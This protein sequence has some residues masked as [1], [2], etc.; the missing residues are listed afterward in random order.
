VAGKVGAAAATVRA[1]VRA[2]AT[3]AAGTAARPS[4]QFR[5]FL[6]LFDVDTM[7]TVEMQRLQQNKANKNQRHPWYVRS[8]STVSRAPIDR[9]ISRESSGDPNLVGD[10]A[11]H[12]VCDH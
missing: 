12:P 1:A 3:A 7:F 2:E 11:A 6:L 5:L 4:K 10:R 8:K 9:P